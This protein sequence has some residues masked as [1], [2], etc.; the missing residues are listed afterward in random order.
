MELSEDKIRKVL[1]IPKEPLSMEAPTGEDEESQVGDFIEDKAVQSPDDQVADTGMKSA[2]DAALS[3]LT[4]RESKVLRMRFGIDSRTDHTLE[5]VSQQFEV[6]R[7]RI[8][9]IEV[10]AIRKL[11]HPSRSNQLKPYLDN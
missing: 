7:E 9:Q 5:E 4:E 8:R 1:M 6:T 3:S 2:I 11:R 10:K